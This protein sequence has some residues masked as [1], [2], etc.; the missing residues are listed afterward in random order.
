VA[1]IV[2]LAGPGV[3][4]DSL[5][6]M[7]ADAINRAAEVPEAQREKNAEL[8]RR[9]LA[10]AASDRGKQSAEA[11]LLQLL[12]KGIP[13]ITADQAR[14]EIANV[15]SPWM[16]W[17]L[18][19]DP[20]PVL[21]RV[22]VPVLA[23]NGSKDLQVPAEPNLS[24]IEAGLAA[25]GNADVAIVALPGL[26]HLLQTADTGLV[27]EYGQIEETIAPV[28]LE[29]IGDWIVARFPPRR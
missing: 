22:S 24:G 15:T 11:E 5:L 23:V 19:Y 7:Q 28:A 13:G 9:M 4:G 27:S 20:A 25:A 16:R 21:R 1:W 2:M 3:R 26:N 12:E 6:V 8:Q 10:I 14:T 18:R 29:T 17:F